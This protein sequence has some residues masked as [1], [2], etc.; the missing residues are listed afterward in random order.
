MV[1]HTFKKLAKRMDLRL[2]ALTT[3]REKQKQQ[4]GGR[5]NL[6]V[7]MNEVMAL[8]V[9]AVVWVYT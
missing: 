6:L 5:R 1:L 4:R 3:K 2:S 9:M 8:I 7:A